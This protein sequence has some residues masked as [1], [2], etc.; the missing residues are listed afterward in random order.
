MRSIENIGLS[1]MLTI[2]FLLMSASASTQPLTVDIRSVDFSGLPRVTFKACIQRDGEIVRGLG[3]S[4]MTL[5]ENGIPRALSVR[6]PLATDINSV[7]LVLDNSG[8]IFAAMPKL[9]EASK[10]LVDSLGPNDEAAIVIFGRDVR[11]VQGFT[12]DKMLLKSVLDAMVAT[13]GTALF[14]ASYMACEELS[15]RSG[16]RHGVIITDGEDNLSTRT[17][18]EVIA[19]A[20]LIGARLHTIAFD[21]APAYRDLMERIAVQTGGAQFF[22]SRP[23]D[24]PTVY[25]TIAA[26]ITEPCCIAEYL[27]GDCVDTLHS[28][29][30]T[31][32]EGGDTGRAQLDVTSPSRAEQTMLSLDVPD[33]L[34]PLAT[35]RG[36]VLMSPVPSPGI[37]LTMSFV[38]EYDQNL[39]DVPLLEFTLGTVTQNQIVKM[40][41]ISPGAT[42]FTLDRIAPALNTP[43]LVGFQIK[44]LVADSSRRVGFRI[45]DILIEGCPTTFFTATDSTLICQC[46]RTLAVG[47]DS[48]KLLSADEEFVL[49]V[50][51]T[52]GIELGL[53]V[54]ADMTLLLPDGAVLL[55][56]TEGNLLEP[57]SVQWLHRGDTLYVMVRSALPRD[58]SGILLQLLFA[59]ERSKVPRRH[60]VR[61]LYTELWQRCCPEDGDLPSITILQ[62]GRCEFLVR[63]VEESIGLSTAPNPLVPGSE[64]LVLLSVPEAL[65]ASRICVD[66]LD[67]QGRSVRRV[68]EGEA[69]QGEMRIGF[70]AAGLPAG[71]YVALLRWNTGVRSVQVVLLR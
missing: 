30:L 10:Q 61:T 59:N 7:V 19:L 49:P 32:T 60:D 13:G 53:T 20:N 22:V 31:V 33:A 50:K 47:L 39:V 9:I 2:V 3:A 16:N 23:G 25:A 11:V 6:C 29:L 38:L 40:E 15:F 66:L 37:A 71:R 41:R 43:L 65:D 56:V 57:G 68:Y 28:L 55:E 44:A 26:L 52:G 63:R 14:D 4:N 62:D 48:L 64:G 36:F 46:F 51:V 54:T 35:D 67:M 42:R 69:R 70:D 1:S 34:T 17:D 21:I 8:S 18:D 12:T 24:L 5:I 58:T 27:T 45:R